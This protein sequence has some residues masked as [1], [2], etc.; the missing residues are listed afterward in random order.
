MSAY[1]DIRIIDFTQGVA[2]PMATMLLADFEADVVKV[3]PPAGDR[4]KDHPGYLCWNRNKRRMVLDLH[5]YEGLHAARELIAGADVAVFDAAPGE[6]ERLGLDAA[7]V[8]AANPRLIHAW[9]PPYGT[10]GRWSQLPPD[11]GLLTAVS[12]CSFLQFSYAGTPVH[13]ITPQVSYGH[14]TISANAIAAALIERTRSGIG[15]AVTVS[16]LN[17]V[18][19]VQ[20]AGATKMEGI[21]R[22]GRVGSR[23]G[24]P[25]YRLYE[26]ADGKWFF[27]GSLTAPFFFKALE[28]VGLIDILGMEGVEGE[29]TNLLQPAIAKVV[30]ERMEARFK[31]KPREEWMQILQDA[32][33]PKG[34]VGIR[35]EWFAGETVAANQMRVELEH[36]KL[37]T[38]AVTGVSAKLAATPGSVRHLMKDAQPAEIA[39]LPASAPS[40]PADTAAA[41]GGP[42]AGIKVIDLGAFI[43]G[44]FAPAILANL[45]ATVIKIEPLDGDPFRPYGLSFFGHNQGKRSLALDMKTDEGREV[46]YELVLKCDVVLDNYRVGVRERL[47]VDYAS[48]AAINPRIITCSVTGY[49][50][51]GELSRDPGFDPL[52]Q[53]RSGMMAAQGGDDEPIF[54]QIAVNDSASAMMAAFAMQTA[55]YARERTG[56]GQEVQTCLASQSV[57]FQSGEV[58]WYEGR[59]PAPVGGLDFIGPRA[60][61]RHYECSDGW[62]A[63]SCSTP[64]QYQHLCVGLGHGEWAGRMTAEQALR[65]PGKGALADLIAGALAGFTRDDAL[66][67]LLARGVPAAPTTRVEEI[68]T[69]PWIAANNFLRDYVHPELGVVTA[70]RGYADYSRTPGGFAYRAPLI[71]EQSAEILAE[72]G[73]SD[74]RI[75]HLV[76]EGIVRQA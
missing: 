69:D 11:D 74:E 8:C 56:L 23:G 31:E 75:R 24:W 65:E 25:H 41:P 40:S 39:A 53:A 7:T 61:Q 44:T 45:G 57:L 42:L 51:E 60:L 43:A 27:L 22:Q 1:R 62:L 68:F 10:T 76:A 38:V 72:F 20:S 12:G 2:G 64:E 4:M 59:P 71:G 18:A 47:G 29:F 55:L 33:V 66:D 19:S 73:F 52:M 21:M 30:L 14:A 28:A 58:T 37:G 16:G 17:A 63:V 46:F 36:P 54:H 9:L 15:Q 35:E 34:P 6:L 50:P 32:G 70:I 48:L 49:G 13:L 5:R 26:C 67:R 3:E